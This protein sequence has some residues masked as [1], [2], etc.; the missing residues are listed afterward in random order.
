MESGKRLRKCINRSL[1]L[2]SRSLIHWSS[3]NYILLILF[4]PPVFSVFA[5]SL[6][7][8][9]GSAFDHR[10]HTPATTLFHYMEG[11]WS[12]VGKQLFTYFFWLLFFIWIRMSVLLVRRP[13]HL[14]LPIVHIP[15]HRSTRGA[16][17]RDRTRPWV[18]GNFPIGYEQYSIVKRDVT[19]FV[20]THAFNIY[21]WN[22]FSFLGFFDQR[23]M[24]FLTQY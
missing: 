12:I 7:F 22:C 11:D 18:N 17:F 10:S 8:W 3:S 1:S 15:N 13:D 14:L 5:F 23:E 2:V 4:P 6:L 9:L 20:T 24:L 21:I 19:L 16:C